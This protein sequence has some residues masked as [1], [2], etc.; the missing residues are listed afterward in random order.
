MSSISELCIVG[1]CFTALRNEDM[2]LIHV[3]IVI[4]DFLLLFFCAYLSH[5]HYSDNQINV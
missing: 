2:L 4:N 1:S 3:I 5:L